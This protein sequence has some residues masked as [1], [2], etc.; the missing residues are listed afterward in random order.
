VTR[1]T[2]RSGRGISSLLVLLAYVLSGANAYAGAGPLGMDHPLAFDQS[3]VWARRNQ[4]T[5]EYGVIG[6]E[7]AG[8]LWLGDDA[9]LGHSLWQSVDASAVSAVG[10]TGLKLVFGRARPN[11]GQG[12]NQW[13]KGRGNQS[14]PS[15]EVTLQ[16]S[17]VT[18]LIVNYAERNPWMWALEVLPLYD[19]VARMKSQA[20]WQ[21]DVLVGWALGTAAGYW[22]T[23]R[24]TPFSVQVLPRGLSLGYSRRF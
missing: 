16:A 1:T 4:L 11:A 8:A 23:K 3:G 9:E 6:F 14:F 7:L 17:F 24:D 5:L 13:F 2:R 21:S 19:G 22:A 12:P 10:A 15:G 20:H 18:P